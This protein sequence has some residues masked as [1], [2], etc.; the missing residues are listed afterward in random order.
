MSDEVKL[1]TAQSLKNAWRKYR[2]AFGEEPHGTL[3]QLKA[4]L[5]FVHDDDSV[6]LS[7]GEACLIGNAFLPLNPNKMRG[8]DPEV[9]SAAI[10]FKHMVS[11][12][13]LKKG[14]SQ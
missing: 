9:K 4:M 5:E 7:L 14:M 1:V 8:A 13:L 6:T 12:K 3:M 2:E 11:Q 10:A